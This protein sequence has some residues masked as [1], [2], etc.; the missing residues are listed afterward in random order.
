MALLLPETAFSQI[1]CTVIIGSSVVIALSREEQQTIVVV[2]RAYRLTIAA[3]RGLATVGQDLAQTSGG[4]WI[5][6]NLNRAAVNAGTA[7]LASVRRLLTRTAICWAHFTLLSGYVR[8]H[9]FGEGYGPMLLDER[10][11]ERVQRWLIKRISERKRRDLDDQSVPKQIRDLENAE[12]IGGDE[13]KDDQVGDEE[14]EGTAKGD[15]DDLSHDH[16]RIE[17][18]RRIQEDVQ[19]DGDHTKDLL[20]KHK[21]PKP[22]PAG[23]ETADYV[24][25][26]KQYCAGVKPNGNPCGRSRLPDASPYFC[27]KAHEAQ[28]QASELHM[29]R[30]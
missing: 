28:F 29:A 7:A 8:L 30:I 3:A 10:E 21:K 24:K 4:A 22:I 17:P 11:Q 19:E 25:D 15:E 16:R 12:G 26:G 6:T 1:G 13:N 23:Y 9:V 2:Q 27:C 14:G 20:R 18:A 5:V